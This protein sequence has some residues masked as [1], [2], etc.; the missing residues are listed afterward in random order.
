MALAR[1][2]NSQTGQANTIT[3]NWR[4]PVDFN[5]SNDEL[6]V[7]KTISHYPM[8]LYNTSFPTKAT[9]SRPIEIYRAS[10]ITG[11]DEGTISVTTDTLTDTTATFSTSPSL[12]GRLIRDSESKVFRIISNTSTS[13]T[14]E[15][16]NNQVIADGKY[17]ILPDFTSITRIQDNFELDIRTTVTG[18]TISDL[19]TIEE[20][21]LLI[22]NFDIEE[23]ANLIFID[24]NNDKFII[25]SNTENTITVYGAIAPTLG[26]GM[27][28]LNSHVETSPLPFVDTYLTQ[29]EADSRAGTGLR[30]DTNYYYTLF[31]LEKNVN[32]AQAEFG[33]KDSG[34]DTQDYTISPAE[35]LFG[36][37]L[38]SLWPGVYRDL[39]TTG[40]LED[41]MST[42]GFFFD[43][44][45]ALI[46]TYKLQDTDN[47]VVTAL[48]PLS[49]QTG[50]PSVG[51]SIGADTLRRIAKDM[52]PCWRLKGTKEG[53]AIFI[54]KITTWDITDGTGD[55]SGSIQDSIP[56]RSALRFFDSNLGSANTRITET[57][58]NFVP[59]GRF[60]RGLP[61]IVIP[62][63]FTFREFVINVPN[64][65]LY[66]GTSTLF[67]TGEDTTTLED[68]LASFGTVN[69]L[70]GNFLLPNQEE[71]ND[72]FEIVSNTNTTITVRGTIN[73]KNV[74]GNYAVLSP[75]NTNR[76][77][78]L[79]KLLPFYIPFG[80]AA[81]FIFI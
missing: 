26:Q 3:L 2:F 70:V 31:T 23:V 10:T 59:G 36:E 57:E 33:A 67:T 48:L 6:I 50:L 12:K 11:L 24:G 64:V 29:G 38:F 41:L 77:I 73:N 18:T 32:V 21:S 63:F 68:N 62:G 51:F 27:R 4:Q 74:G 66:I 28:I 72:I 65:A 37:R 39:D 17:I 78:I 34:V 44:L 80:T 75:L 15:L 55:F 79:N 60:A 56:N 46:K 22:K 52:I 30:D 1:D 43:E 19:I 20:G 49:E 9:D 7:T 35:K 13:I 54:R 61:G 69:S 53:I 16:V 5:L 14:V 71:I 58:P 40:D 81:G 25:K 8:E 45:H 42:F 76:F 47:V